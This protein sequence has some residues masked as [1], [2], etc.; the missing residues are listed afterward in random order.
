MKK[1]EKKHLQVYRLLAIFLSMCLIAGSLPMTAFAEE[2]ENELGGSDSI[3]CSHLH[4]ENCGHVEAVEGHEC[5]HEHDENC[6]YLEAQDEVPCD[7]GC[8]ELDENGAVIHEEGCA[9]RQAVESQECTHE[10]NEACGYIEAVEGQPCNHE[11]DEICGGLET[12][13][14]EEEEPE[15]GPE[16][17][18]V[19]AYSIVAEDNSVCTIGENSYASLSEA[20]NDAQDNAVIWMKSDDETEQRLD[21]SKSLTIELQ[22]YSL[23]NTVMKISGSGTLVNLNDRAGVSK[24]N[25]NHVEGYRAQEHSRCSSTI[26]ITDGASV[27][28]NGSTGTN[29][30]NGTIIYESANSDLVKA[31][32]VGSGN[33]TINGGTFVGTKTSGRDG[34]FVYNGR[35]TINDGYFYSNCGLSYYTAP[36]DENPLVIK[37]G[38]FDGG[39]WIERSGSINGISFSSGMQSVANVTKLFLSGSNGSVVLNGSTQNLIKIGSGLF[40]SDSVKTQILSD[41]SIIA[42]GSTDSENPEKINPADRVTVTLQPQ[43]L[44]GDGSSS[45][46]YEWTKDG[47]PIQNADESSYTI[48]SYDSESDAGQYT[49]TAT[50]GDSTLTIYY[51][52]GE[53]SNQGGGDDSG[54]LSVEVRADAGTTVN[55]DKDSLIAATITDEENASNKKITVQMSIVNKT[56]STPDREKAE[57]VLGGI[58]ATSLGAYFDITLSK[59]VAEGSGSTSETISSTRS[60][61]EITI[62]IPDDLL[63][64]SNYQVIRVHGDYGAKSAEALSTTRTE[65]NLTFKTDK[66]STYIIAYTPYNTSDSGDDAGGGTGSGSGSDA[67]SN[68]GSGGGNDAGSGTGSN[69]GESTGSSMEATTTDTGNVVPSNEVITELSPIVTAGNNNS[70]VPSETK[71]KEPK[72]GDD[73]LPL[74]TI[75]MI[76]GLAYLTELFREKRGIHFGMTEDQKNKVISYLIQRAKGKHALIRYAAVAAIFMILIFYHSIGKVVEFDGRELAEV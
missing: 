23:P 51:Q 19:A 46:S 1:K 68:T 35:V 43:I 15:E 52:L 59:T 20:I 16:Q 13:L 37:K 76:A 42:V 36:S 14:L 74:A 44:G 26:Y 73:Q 9:Y 30:S 48:S 62:A 58:P 64:G 10:H 75:G 71:A 61:I 25:E 57:E 7:K 45:I 40:V 6:G 70:D 5:M 39:M 41:G 31:I 28:I 47:N 29:S 32:F 72:T 3:I 38:I 54:S 53:K 63:G 8:S 21:I 50:Q 12:T 67:G 24:I 17:L 69:T 55:V 56:N 27:M 34:L 60:Q 33:L 65:N 22:G 66:F 2:P 18:I 4:D 11:H 49:M